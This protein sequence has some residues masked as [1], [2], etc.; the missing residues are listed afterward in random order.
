MNV[1]MD[2]VKVLPRPGPVW[3]TYPLRA[4]DDTAPL[5]RRLRLTTLLRRP[6]G[7]ARSIARAAAGAAAAWHRLDDAARAGALLAVRVRL[8]R[9][10]L[11]PAAAAHAL[12]IAAA[13][14]T[15]V[16]G[17]TPRETQILAAAVLL[18]QRM[19]EMATGEGKT[20]ALALAAAVGAMAGM[21]VHVVTA[22]EY[23]ARRDAAWLAPFFAA[24]GLR[25]AA[26]P[27][28]REDIERRAVYEHDVVYATARELAFDYLRDRLAFGPRSEAER[29]AAALAGASN[30]PPLMRGLCMA[31]LD[32]ADSILLDE[33]DVPLILSRNVP[34]AARRAF[35]WQALAVA[36]QLEPGRD[37]KI[38][39]SE[40]STVSADARI[41]SIQ[42]VA[43]LFGR[44]GRIWVKQVAE[45][46]LLRV[47][48]SA[49]P[50]AAEHD[51]RRGDSGGWVRIRNECH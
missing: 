19:A 21:P 48:L 47:R 42:V 31:L 23:L 5:W 9:E 32:E 38:D 24:L 51:V 12:G 2:I 35:L 33:A 11:T 40:R 10:G 44:L 16:L 7:H 6:L 8:R 22:N 20:L 13:K 46:A 3:G 4:A 50:F 30:P 17:Q 15:E 36:R 45:K 27:V 1:P 37:F 25:A 29:T 39:A 41:A 26:L 34:Q 43:R 28:G 14:A 49:G 18:D